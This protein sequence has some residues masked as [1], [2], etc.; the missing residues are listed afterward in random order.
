AG[1]V[2]MIAGLEGHLLSSAFVADRVASVDVEH[3]RARFGSWR[4]RCAAL[5]PASVPRTIF[6]AAATPFLHA[7]G[8]E[9]LTM[10]ESSQSGVAATAIAAGRPVAIAVAA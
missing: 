3:V 9:S 7:L 5:G 4:T 6:Q 1:D 10:I 2:P 8:F